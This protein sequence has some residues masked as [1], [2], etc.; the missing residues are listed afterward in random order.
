MEIELSER[1]CTEYFVEFA[2]SN[3]PIV[4]KLSLKLHVTNYLEINNEVV[5]ILIS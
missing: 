2:F 3:I 1:F 5:R 4:A